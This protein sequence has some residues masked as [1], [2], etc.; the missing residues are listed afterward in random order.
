MVL[1]AHVG[2]IEIILPIRIRISWSISDLEAEDE[3]VEVEINVAL[4]DGGRIGICGIAGITT[5]I[6]VALC[7][8]H[9]N[10][11]DDKH[12]FLPLW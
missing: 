7:T 5:F 2:R 12:P 11:L 1:N 4:S 8:K 10:L 9:G 3:F 6:G